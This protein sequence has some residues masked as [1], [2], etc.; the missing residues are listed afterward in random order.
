M[1]HEILRQ[2]WQG[3]NPKTDIIIDV[4]VDSKIEQK[5]ISVKQTTAPKVAMA[6]FDVDTIVKEIGI[7]DDKLKYYL[8]KHQT[9]AS[10]KNFTNEEKED[11][12]RRLKPYLEKFIRWVVSGTP[13][14]KSD[15]RYPLAIIR[16][17]LNKQIQIEDIH[18]DTID[19]YVNSIIY[20]SKGNPKK[21][22]FGTGLGWTYATG[23]KGKKIQFKG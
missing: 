7:K 19:Q 12:T 21:G 15:L 14:P 8:L 18:C 17:K 2:E 1:L 23:S 5:T 4:F 10:A 16:F 6:E 22:G 11:L 9:D 3:G 20:N 13:E